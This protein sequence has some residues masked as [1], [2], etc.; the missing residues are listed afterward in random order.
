M[1]RVTRSSTQQHHLIQEVGDPSHPNYVRVRN[2]D[3][4]ST[5]N[6]ARTA[7]DDLRNTINQNPEVQAARVARAQGKRPMID[8]GG[9]HRPDRVQTGIAPTTPDAPVALNPQHL[10]QQQVQQMNAQQKDALIAFLQ[11]MVQP[12]APMEQ[13]LINPAQGSQLD[14]PLVIPNEGESE[15]NSRHSHA[16]PIPQRSRPSIYSRLGSSRDP[17]HPR[18]NGDH[19]RDA[20]WAHHYRNREQNDLRD[21]LNNRRQQRRAESDQPRNRHQSPPRGP[22]LDRHNEQRALSREYD[23]GPRDGLAVERIAEQNA[24]F[25]EQLD[26][27]HKKVDGDPD[28][29]MT[30][31]PFTVRLEA[32]PRDKKAKHPQ[33][34]FYNG[35][36]NPGDHTQFFDQQM[37]LHDYND[38]TKCRLFASTLEGHAQKWFSLLAPRSVDTWMEFRAAFLRRFRANRPHDIHTVSLEGIVQK[39][40]ESLD[41][42]ILRFKEGVNR[43]T[44]VDQG[45]AISAFRRGL[46]SYEYKDYVLDLICKDPKDLA[47]VYAM[48]SEYITGDNALRAMRLTRQREHHEAKIDQHMPKEF[49]HVPK[50]FNNQHKDKKHKNNGSGHHS[51]TAQDNASYRVANG[52]RDARPQAP[53]AAKPPPK[54]NQEWTRFSRSTAVILQEIK[55]KPFFEKPRPMTTPITNRDQTKF[56]DYHEDVG[57]ATNDCVAFKYFLERQAKAGNMNNYLPHGHANRAGQEAPKR[58]AVLIVV[59]GSPPRPARPDTSRRGEVMEISRNPSARNVISFSDE[60]YE[61]REPNHNEA[62]VINSDVA[63]HDVHKMLVDNGSAVDIIFLHALNRM[64]IESYKLEPSDQSLYGF[65]HNVVQVDGIILLPVTFGSK[66]RE[67]CHMIKFHV[68]NTASPYNIILGRPTMSKLRAITSVTHLKLKFPTPRG[69][70][71]VKA[72]LGVAGLCYRAALAMGE[73]HKANRRKVALKQQQ[74][75][76]PL[77]ASKKASRQAAHQAHMAEQRKRQKYGQVFTVETDPSIRDPSELADHP[78]P[79]PLPVEATEQIELIRGDA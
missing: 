46:D 52:N 41:N 4:D 24:R 9:Q 40:G 23:H 61:G 70:G 68:I 51:Y 37:A 10:T 12:S 74:E 26:Q 2:A 67:V 3:S 11:S 15:G 32:Q 56:C 14:N 16:P 7:S 66:P 43:V 69:V 65:G 1:R 78:N 73:T 79:R 33:L 29:E 77:R 54:P 57:H 47:K 53:N 22:I 62:L 75:S 6:A 45:E 39:K 58:P 55:G 36:K 35:D 13:P 59:G 5:L 21:Q 71:V 63:G 25:Q 20:T 31:S 60:D 76:A 72:E 64:N 49:Q 17:E 34:R 44:S 50:E 48:A 38:L 28:F 42:Y 18:H 8:V 19:H 27:L 30:E